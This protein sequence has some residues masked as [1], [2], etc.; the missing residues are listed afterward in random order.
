MTSS[1][2]SNT[3][4][5]N[6][7]NIFDTDANEI[8]Y[9]IPPF[10][11]NYSWKKD[12]VSAL[13]D[14]LLESHKNEDIDSSTAQYL[15]G[16]TVLIPEPEQ[17]S[18]YNRII[19][20]QQRF[21][22]LTLYFCAIRDLYL[23]L[24]GKLPE[25]NELLKIIANYQTKDSRTEFVSW[26]LTLNDVD[27]KLFEKLQDYQNK[28]RSFITY[29]DKIKNVEKFKKTSHKKLID[30]YKTLYESILDWMVE[31]H[32]KDISKTT[33]M[34]E[35]KTLL[36]DHSPSLLSLSKNTMKNIFFVVIDGKDNTTTIL[37]DSD[38]FQIFETL[39]TRGQTLNKSNLVKSLILSCLSRK[40]FNLG[41]ESLSDPEFKKLTLHIQEKWDT[42]FNET[43]G[44]QPDDKFLI[45]SIKSRPPYGN[46]PIS[47][48]GATK[49]VT[50]HTVYDIIKYR[51]K[52]SSE[53]ESSNAEEFVDILYDDSQFAEKLN[54]PIKEYPNSR[55]ELRHIVGIKN[56]NAEYI[57]IPLYVSYRKC[58]DEFEKNKTTKPY[59]DF[60]ML[61]VFLARFFFRYKTIREKPPQQLEK[62]ILEITEAIATGQK[63]ENIFKLVLLHDDDDDFKKYLKSAYYDMTNSTYAAHIFKTILNVQKPS[64]EVSE[65]KLSLEHVFPV[66]KS[67]WE[68]E[69]ERNSESESDS[70][71]QTTPI[72]EL[73]KCRDYLGNMVLLDFTLN[74]Q[75]KNDVY[76]NKITQYG[77]SIIPM[78]EKEILCN[79]ESGDK[80]NEWT[81]D[82]IVKRTDH[83]YEM[84][85]D[86]WKLPQIKCDNCSCDELKIKE[87]L[88]K[89]TIEEIEKIKCPECTDGNLSLHPEDWHGLSL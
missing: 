26:K 41:R 21:A 14:D 11:R 56:L 33:S 4:A 83:L 44:K 45:E 27:R 75:L 30:A 63:L 5:K 28:D 10:Q 20:G 82:Y 51:I 86:Y 78:V 87:S 15:L 12:N 3:H 62:I 80:M 59:D 55:H 61:V 18:S 52:Y 54:D 49:P 17:N 77:K 57:R 38:A 69:F 1:K 67:K 32:C 79:F 68:E 19:D 6:L 9:T 39:N 65:D 2:F 58:K 37:T 35:K 48:S 40:K 31:K 7:R 71:S 25:D 22:T 36:K 16:A 8:L 76:S 42:I 46:H 53:F 81:S 64:T 88:E 47:K 66:N 50:K 24:T 23:E 89:K 34:A 72:D 73:D 74:S 70:E 60:K 29:E 13:W 85:K 43:V 84:S